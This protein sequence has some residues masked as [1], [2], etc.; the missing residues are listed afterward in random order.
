M[1][2]TFG[3][4]T[5]ELNPSGGNYVVTLDEKAISVQVLR[6]ENG[7]MDLSIAGE[8]VTAYVSSDK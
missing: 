6:A 1:K 2:I 5:L 3:Q 4:Q 7:R 8:R